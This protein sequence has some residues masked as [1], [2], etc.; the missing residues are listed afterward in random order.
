[1]ARILVV[2]D[3]PAIRSMLERM[4]TRLGHEVS[5]APDGDEAL[6]QFRAAPF[7]LV[8]TDLMMPERDGIE[9]IRELVR[10]GQ[11]RVIAMSGGGRSGQ[12]MP[13]KIA[14]HVG[15]MVILSKPFSN[16]E[17]EHAIEAALSED[18]S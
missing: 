12:T 17:L 8:I 16:Q 10:L 2:D 9:T 13:L 14:K 4:I 6:R 15:A 18:T 7:D 1:M 5:V 3:E 11:V